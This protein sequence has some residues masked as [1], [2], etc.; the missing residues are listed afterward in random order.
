MLK[1][2]QPYQYPFHMA[3]RISNNLDILA[4]ARER[5]AGPR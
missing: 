3:S 1:M 2:Q 4:D 5:M